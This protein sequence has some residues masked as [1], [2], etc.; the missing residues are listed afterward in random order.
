MIPAVDLRCTVEAPARA[1][2]GQPLMVRFVLTNAGSAP[3]QVLRW[4]T[5]WE[6]G[7]FAPFVTVT[8]DGK[9]LRYEGPAFKRGD[10]RVDQ[11]LLLP[12]RT[13]LTASLDLALPFNLSQPGRYALKPRIRALDAFD[14]RVASA[15]RARQWQQSLDLACPAVEFALE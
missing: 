5:P 7:W 13:S 1:P 3:V 6:G 14:A 10:P 11:Y 15:P 12:V 8:R 9:P 2:A 4:N